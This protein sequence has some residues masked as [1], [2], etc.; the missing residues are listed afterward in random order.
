MSES[1]CG[2]GAGMEQPRGWQVPNQN[3]GRFKDALLN[4]M[5][6]AGAR[7]SSEFQRLKMLIPCG[8]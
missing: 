7:G 2:D 4:L 5:K 3:W 8:F 1:D 6:T